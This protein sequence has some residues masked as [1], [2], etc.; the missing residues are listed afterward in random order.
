MLALYFGTFG[1]KSYMVELDKRRTGI[2][3]SGTPEQIGRWIPQIVGTAVR[4]EPEKG[5]NYLFDAM[6]QI[7]AACIY[8][9]VKFV[10]WPE[11]ALPANSTIA[12]GTSTALGSPLVPEVKIIMNVSIGPTSAC[13]SSGPAL[14]TDEAHS[15]DSTSTTPLMSM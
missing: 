12:C 3:A 7:K 9:F 2:A 13:G 15:G 4:F 10:D 11:R 1:G 5:L 8:N 14:A 6:P